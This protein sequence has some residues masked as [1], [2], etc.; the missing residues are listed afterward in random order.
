[1]IYIVNPLLQISGI[2]TFAAED[3][4]FIA[5]SIFCTL[6]NLKFFESFSIPN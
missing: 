4:S 1:M 2:V 3:V 6:E 5:A